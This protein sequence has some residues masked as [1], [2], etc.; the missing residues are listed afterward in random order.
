MSRPGLAEDVPAVEVEGLRH[1]YGAREALA[2]VS[3][4]V[5]RGEMVGLLGPNGG[6]K[7]T[8]FKILS[9]LLP[10]TGGAVRVFGQALGEAPEAIRGRL[11]VVFQQ[12][13]LDPKLTVLENLRHHGRLY[14]WHGRLLRARAE[15]M[16]DRMGLGERAH[17]LGETL[18]GGLRRRAELAKALLPRPELLLLDEP[19][20]GLDPGARRELA[21]YLEEL[22]AGEGVTILLT[23]HLMDEAERC[24]R[25]GIL[26]RGRL[27]TID[28]PA[29]LKAR[30]GGDVV[31]IQARDPEA[32]RRL[33]GERFGTQPA[34]VDGLLRAERPR[35]HEFVREVAE[36]FP[37]EVLSAS[38]GRP[39][40]EDVFVHLTGSRLRRGEG[41]GEAA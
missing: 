15:A 23:T 11:G 8:L 4:R 14:G 37:G 24:D 12:P 21:A 31:V 16:L 35:G 36:A 27:V 6:G 29:E 25:V 17:D 30:L 9:T 20:T 7:T 19:S 34:L 26:D 18:S 3:F 22:R 1:R 33:V 32:L 28:R 38:F 10:P 2:G 40:L 13:S 5:A 41:S 39:T